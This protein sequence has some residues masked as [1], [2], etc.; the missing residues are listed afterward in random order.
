MQLE[1]RYA[2]QAGA[3][4]A[5][6]VCGRSGS[7]I[8]PRPHLAP[9]PRVG[10]HRVPVGRSSAVADGPAG[11]PKSVAPCPASSVFTTSWVPTARGCRSPSPRTRTRSPPRRRPSSPRT[12]AAA[13]P[14]SA[15][16]RPR[17]QPTAYTPT[18]RRP[19]ASANRRDCRCPR[20]LVDAQY[21]P[22]ESDAARLTAHLADQTR[23]HAL[24]TIELL[25]ALEDSKRC[26]RR[27]TAAGEA[28]AAPEETDTRQHRT[29]STNTLTRDKP[30]PDRKLRHSAAASVLIPPTPR[31]S[32]VTLVI[33]PPAQRAGQV[34]NVTGRCDE[35]RRAGVLPTCPRDRWTDRIEDTV[36][37]RFHP[38]APGPLPEGRGLV[39]AAIEPLSAAH[40]KGTVLAPVRRTNP[41]RRSR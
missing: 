11:S 2:R 7:A 28:R 26:L 14:H 6:Q 8:Y 25:H 9:G 32:P 27:W 38:Y 18:P 37:V 40:R 15:G 30:G 3:H 35:A 20:A 4:I 36:R 33:R 29:I 22:S 39:V 13:L 1:T 10:R 5:F 34:R 16:A 23:G 31:N 19:L 17:S 24:F 12:L 41:H 21:A